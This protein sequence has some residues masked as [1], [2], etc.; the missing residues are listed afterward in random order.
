MF[1][2]LVFC[3]ELRVMMECVFGMKTWCLHA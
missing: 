2:L 3:G 1:E